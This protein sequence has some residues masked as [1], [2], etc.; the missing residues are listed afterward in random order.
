[1][2]AH[3]KTGLLLVN[4]GSPS[5]P[6]TAAVRT[7]LRE[8]LSDPRVLDMPAAA[9]W[10]LLNAIILPFR[11]PKSAHAYASIWT[12]QGS[13]LISHTADLSHKVAALL[14]NWQVAHAM[15]YGEPALVGALE[16]LLKAG[17]TR[18][19]VFPLYPQYASSSTGT[20]LDTVFSWAAQRWNTPSLASIGPFYQ[21]PAFISAFAA[22]AKP[23]LEAFRPDFTVFSYHGLPLRHVN[24]CV[25]RDDHPRQ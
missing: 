15:R 14:P 9:R 6:T 25:L 11:S 21:H 23:Q 5:A 1:M 13:P 20:A 16:Q 22:V 3:E 4:L 8:F 7:Y 17:C 24:T 12:E 19:I 10:L 2:S 18:L